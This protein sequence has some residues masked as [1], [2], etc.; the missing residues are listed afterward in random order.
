[1]TVM[2]LFVFPRSTWRKASQ[3]FGMIKGGRL[4][5]FIERSG[6]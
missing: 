5:G 6:G 4:A 1:M 3:A 2:L